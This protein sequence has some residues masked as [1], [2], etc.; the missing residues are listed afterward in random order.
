MLSEALV[1]SADQ[2]QTCMWHSVLAPL[3]PMHCKRPVLL[4][5]RLFQQTK[6]SQ[7]RDV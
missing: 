2:E 1:V 4:P 3:A 6:L 7:I 5:S